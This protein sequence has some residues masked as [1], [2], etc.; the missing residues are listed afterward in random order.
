MNQ[1]N[2]VQ[3][4]Y[5]LSE[6]LFRA[7]S[8]AGG[9]EVEAARFSFPDATDDEDVDLDFWSCCWTLL[10]A[11]AASDSGVLVKWLRCLSMA[12]ASMAPLDGAAGVDRLKVADEGPVGAKAAG[13]VR[14]P[15]SVRKTLRTLSTQGGSGR[16]S[17]TANC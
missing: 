11:I 14:Q 10:L 2:L 8:G 15:G 9:Y 5:R 1:H 3:L 7:D 4:D 17:S 16:G 13:G 12:A 6:R